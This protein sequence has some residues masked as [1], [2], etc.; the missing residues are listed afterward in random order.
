MLS[1]HG[2]PLSTGELTVILA[3]LANCFKW[4][5]NWGTGWRS[6][7]SVPFGRR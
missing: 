5:A 7:R 3:L 4:S 6:H 1:T 2:I